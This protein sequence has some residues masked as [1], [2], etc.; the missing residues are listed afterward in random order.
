MQN[1]YIGWLVIERR[2]GYPDKIYAEYLDE[3]GARPRVFF[4]STT[5]AIEW[6]DKRAHGEVV[7]ES[8]PLGAY[9]VRRRE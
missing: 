4:Q 8:T 3:S 9:R 7:L 6:W 5:E 2:E 1:K